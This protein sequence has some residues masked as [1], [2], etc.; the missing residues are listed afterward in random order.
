MDVFRLHRQIVDDY[1]A[2]SRSFVDVRDDRVAKAVDDAIEHGALWPEP[3]V[4]LNPSFEPGATP[5]ELVE[6][7]VLHP[8]C[9]RIFRIK[10]DRGDFGRPLR[11]HRHQT[12]AI[13]AAKER[14]N[15]VLTTG[16]GSGK[17]LAYLIPI[18]DRV[19][20]DGPGRG[21]RAIIVYPMNALANSQYGELE[22][23]IR[24]GYAPGT[25]PLRY[26]RYT[27][28]ENDD[29]REAILIDPPDIILTNYVMLELMLT[30]GRERKRLMGAAKGSLRF[31]V[32]DELHTYRGRQGSD[33]AMLIR[34]VRDVCEVADLQLVG[35]SATM[36]SGGSEAEQREEVARVTSTLF[37]AQVRPEHVIG[38]SLR[39]A[40]PPLDF[41]DPA[42][43]DALRRRLEQQQDA[44]TEYH[45]FLQDPLS[46][47]IESTF[48]LREVTETGRLVR[49]A[50]RA[51]EG[52][53]GAAAELAELTGVDPATCADAIRRQLLAGYRALDEENG[54]PAFAFRLHQ[55][56]TT[57]NSVFASLDPE[58]ERYV[59][60]EGQTFKP[61]DR[62]RVLL[63]LAFCRECGQEYY[64]VFRESD[65]TLAPRD[66]G[67][68]G[69]LG[70]AGPQAGFLHI[71]SG[72]PWPTDQAGVLERVPDSWL[73]EEGGIVRVDANRR[74]EVPRRVSVDPAGH[75]ADTGPIEVTWFPTP[76]RF[77]LTCG[78]SYDPSLRSDL[79][80]LT[81]L[82]SG[83][84][85]S[86]TTVL[87][88]STVRGLR[89]D[90]SLEP[91]ARKL[92]SFSDNR[93]D[94]SLQAG[95]FND[96]VEV[97][98]LRGALYRAVAVA[99]RDGLRS[100]DLVNAVFE[101]LDLPVKEYAADP[102]G[103]RFAA[104]TQT[105][106]A[107]RAVVSY[108]LYHDLKRGW[109]V[110]MP[111]L[112]QTGLLRIEYESVRELA[113]AD[114]IWQAKHPVLVTASAATRERV[115]RVLLDDLRRNLAIHVEALDPQ[116][117]EAIKS[118]S[119]SWLSHRWAI[120]PDE[121][122]EPS[123]VARPRPRRHFDLRT[124]HFISGW[125]GFARWLRKGPTFGEWH[126]EHL[127][128]E[129][130]QQVI[131][132][133]LDALRVAG[134]VQ[135]VSEP[136]GD[137]EVAGYQLVAATM[138]WRPGDATAPSHDPIRSPDRPEEGGRVNPF[139]VD[140]YRQV[141]ANLT[142]LEARE[143][144]AQVLAELRQ[145]REDDFR[146]A[147]LPL[148]FCS[149]TMELGVDIAQLNAVHL[150]NVPP[151]PASYAQRSG[152]AGRSGQPAIITTYCSAGSPH[153][154]YF[155]RRADR[156][157]AGVV[158]P[159]R[160]ELANED[161]VRSH[162]HAIWLAETGAQ[163][164][165]SMRD[166]LDLQD[167]GYPLRSEIQ[168]QIDAREA[169]ERARRRA[170]AVLVTVR[171]D[172]D[173]ASW[174]TDSWVDEV[175]TTVTRRF[176][177]AFDRWR[178]LFRAAS[179]Q[180]LEQGRVA[181]DPAAGPKEKRR[182]RRLRQQ[183]EAQMDLL[184]AD[185]TQIRESDFYPYRYLASEGFLPGYSFPRL[186]LSAFIP[187]QRN[188]DDY[189]QRPRF[190]A[191]SEFGP[192]ALVYHEGSRYQID[193][194]I[195][196]AGERDDE[197]GLPLDAAKQ[198]DRCGYLHP[199]DGRVGPDICERCGSELGETLIHLF[200]MHNVITRRRERINSDEE[201]RQRTG[202]EIR[203]GVRFA[204]YGA[205]AGATTVEVAHDGA[206]LLKLTYGDAADI[207][208]INLGW[209]R[210]SEP[211]R[212]GYVLD[213][214]T[215]RWLA[216]SALESQSDDP[217]PSI[218]EGTRVERVTPYVRDRRNCLILETAEA[219]QPKELASLMAAL[220]NGMQA[221]FELEDD[222]LAAEP[223]PTEDDPRSILLYE[224]AE[225]GAGA[226]RRLVREPHA[227]RQVALEAL[228]ICHFDPATG[229]DLGHAPG[230]LQPCEAACYDCLMSYRN[231]REHRLLDRQLVRPRLLALRDATVAITPTAPPR[232][233][234]FDQLR[235]QCDSSLELAFL[236]LLERHDLHPP[237]HAQ[238]LI[239]ACG[240]RPDF[241][242]GP[243]YTAVWIDGPLHD[244]PD[245]KAR[246]AE[247]DAC[248]EDMGYV[249]LRFRH[250][251]QDRW[252]GLVRQHPTV[253]GELR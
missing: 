36:V 207:W 14:A 210:R 106:R 213:L 105:D 107:L 38:E 35:T 33:V 52:P 163:L 174:F 125:G 77:C 112:E 15:Y 201:E 158:A 40:S 62:S 203:T 18:V 7:G 196:P 13:P 49:R 232:S 204:Q 30:R 247:T 188:R 233:Q 253:F 127:S 32:L 143:H 161:L 183:A 189:L 64:T 72:R 217:L 180:A 109:R 250:D 114:D 157:V 153:D 66:I 165:G 37:G 46:S 243:D 169:V 208:R 93:Q 98:L 34:R 73:R 45:A 71:D 67:D 206:P 20:R 27:G 150:R 120:D 198:C 3:W 82:S 43:A 124:D 176:D 191:I 87:T 219:L 102:E 186:P 212:R 130:S 140:F 28:Q 182:A 119:F 115:C 51:V 139:F 121:Q 95:H 12:D 175:F 181:Q 86:A 6:Q 48:G 211:V 123:A 59:T 156:M 116:R 227:L 194:V 237:S 25:E 162:L 160:L 137:Q 136:G 200:R 151:T 65:G 132:E 197:G 148:L 92:L 246:D 10:K 88:L 168:E 241:L 214:E 173:Q 199:Y 4:Q 177:A 16:T 75:I 138:I 145:Q 2:F 128:R 195:I 113:E 126:D 42:T 209:R 111:N 215:G 31:L 55:F 231:Q 164:G 44:P 8:E 236:D 240:C 193:R 19:L 167:E 159:P 220:K 117:Q 90:D 78:V 68:R 192:G 103:Q 146:A 166:V 239:D 26:A 142:G 225:G 47:W 91:D 187:G 245:L 79:T 223:L 184:T 149:P 224:A 104:K 24:F 222:E 94:A 230:T 89:A 5:D 23:F 118:Q 29:E 63:P 229:E 70:P 228:A 216:E 202:H 85:S 144:T 11:L 76:F 69:R 83:G 249:S 97:A 218:S 17:S 135:V 221:T 41:K 134:L 172:L 235:A 122:M 21:V 242:Y 178:Q 190:L 108:R 54:R 147:R 226:L 252:L 9:G 248:L 244:Q 99:G 133:L 1:A 60:L 205:R 152:R 84:R 185:A 110:T 171:D 81:L 155:F 131:R 58:D 141:A 251:E 101:A 61:G 234:K 129:D 154:Q 238:K 39:R 170:E 56:L 57:G 80:K 22:K 53:E 100:E 96:F 179:E 50:P 74:D